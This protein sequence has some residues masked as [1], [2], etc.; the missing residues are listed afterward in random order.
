MS[1]QS[2]QTQVSNI[3]AI[4]WYAYV[5]GFLIGVIVAVTGIVIA[6][7]GVFAGIG[8]NLWGS[9]LLLGGGTIAY[10]TRRAALRVPERGV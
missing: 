8:W 3:G 5:V 2:E 10:F 7:D 1:Q 6:I 4:E 9:I